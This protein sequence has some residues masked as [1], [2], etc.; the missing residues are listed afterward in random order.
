MNSFRFG[1]EFEFAGIERKTAAGI[2]ADVFESSA[3]HEGGEL[4]EYIIAD[5]KARLWR[6]VRDASI[7]AYQDTEQCEL[8]TPVLDLSDMNMVCSILD[9]LK[10]AGAAT[11]I[12]CGMHIH[13]DAGSFIPQAIINLV[14]LIDSNEK[15]IYKALGISKDRLRY[16][17]RI[18]DDLI[19]LLKQRKPES[20]A[21]LQKAWYSESPYEYVDGKYHSTRYH[22][23]NLHALYYK[24][25][26]EFR[27]FNGS[28]DADEVISYLQFTLAL[29]KKAKDNKR[30]VIKSGPVENEKYAFRCF[31]LRLGLIGD[32]YKV[33]RKILLKN[34]S[35]DCAWKG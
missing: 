24:G 6:V 28:L 27:L 2:V 12:S 16:C 33:C 25:T 17:K 20:I 11:N 18:N 14:A 30:A 7:S 35:G 3:F 22:G 32:E 34:L 9:T 4:D 8:V 23:L 29:C 10:A 26:I 5:K 15:L 31:L 1:I 13:V 19:N 21:D